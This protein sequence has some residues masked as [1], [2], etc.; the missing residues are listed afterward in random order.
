LIFLS[1]ALK[2]L[3]DLYERTSKSGAVGN[4]YK[5]VGKKKIE[6]LMDV[7]NHSSDLASPA[8]LAYLLIEFERHL[9]FERLNRD[10]LLKRNEWIANLLE[11]ERF[12]DAVASINTL[13]NAIREPPFFTLA[14]KAITEESD[15]FCEAPL[16][17][18]FLIMEFVVD[19][20]D[21]ADFCKTT[22]LNDSKLPGFHPS[23][24]DKLVRQISNFG[25]STEV[26]MGE[27]VNYFK[28]VQK[29]PKQDWEED[30]E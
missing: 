25:S 8:P 1:P 13:S 29:E 28:T 18:C 21:V 22:L 17:I 23:N 10:F 24:F 12:E 27:F 9:I 4:W 6:R 19:I 11:C 3:M 15:L 2:A 16:E 5:S 26:Q 14:M 30:D 20:S 7:N